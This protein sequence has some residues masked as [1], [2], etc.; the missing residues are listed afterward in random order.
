M[1]A[2]VVHN[3]SY[4]GGYKQ[5]G[6]SELAANKAVKGNKE[7][8][9]VILNIL[10]LNPNITSDEI[11]VYMLE[12]TENT[13][14]MSKQEYA[15]RLIQKILYIRPR[16][17]ELIAQGKI[18]VVGRG[19]SFSGNAANIHAIAQPKYTYSENGQGVLV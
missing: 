10:T 15:Q 6:T 12:Y 2:I 16:V 5:S 4:E 17:S 1:G 18:D 7:I 9:P 19:K 3:G 11:A 8:Y 14:A 13:D